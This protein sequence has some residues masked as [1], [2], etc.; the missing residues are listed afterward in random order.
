M[1]TINTTILTAAPPAVTLIG[2]FIEGA[3]VTAGRAKT[4]MARGIAAITVTITT[5]SNPITSALDTMVT[6]VDSSTVTSAP[7][8]SQGRSLFEVKYSFV[9]TRT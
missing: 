6:V 9:A 2:A 1:L 5:T 8:V 4:I 7:E 3:Y